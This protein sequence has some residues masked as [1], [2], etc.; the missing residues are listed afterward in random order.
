[1]SYFEPDNI[2][3]SHTL[4]ISAW[5][6]LLCGVLTL[7]IVYSV[8]RLVNVDQGAQVGVVPAIAIG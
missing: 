2:I 7:D 1:M 6:A 8:E 4:I 5:T 3:L